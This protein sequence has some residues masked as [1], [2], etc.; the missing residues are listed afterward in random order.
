M[1]SPHLLAQGSE[2]GIHLHFGMGGAWYT[3]DLSE[4]D[5]PM[6]RAQPMLN[7]GINITGKGW[8]QPR[9]GAAFGSFTEQVDGTAPPIAPEVTNTDYVRTT[10]TQLDVQLQAVLWSKKR[11]SLSLGAGAGLFFFS[12]QN[13]E[14][15][16]LIDNPFTRLPGEEYPGA[17]VSYPLTAAVNIR[18][19]KNIG[20]RAE[21]TYRATNTDYLDNLGALGAREGNDRLQSVAVGFWFGLK[22]P[23]LEGPSGPVPVSP[24]PRVVKLEPDPGPESGEQTNR[25][26][27]EAG[28][29]Q[30]KARSGID[31]QVL[32]EKALKERRYVYHR[33]KRK[34]RLVDIA[35]R[36][37][38]RIETLRRVNF[39]VNDELAE[40]SLLRIPDV[41]ID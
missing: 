34:E 18:L 33:V 26:E 14:G 37:K 16:F 32:E 20:L 41:K 25:P 36:Y 1:F 22:P 8:F 17:A 19:R 21:Y 31:Y 11:L 29:A 13:L 30:G 12:P 28:N 24:E 2:G 3:G 9:L 15:D 23:R 6:L 40:G 10:F 39:L 38:V 5:L 7:A 27:E 35:E 4:A